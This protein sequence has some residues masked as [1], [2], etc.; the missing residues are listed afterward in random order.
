LIH[1]AQGSKGK[2]RVDNPMNINVSS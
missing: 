2:R 1:N